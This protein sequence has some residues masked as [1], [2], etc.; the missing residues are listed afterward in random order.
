MKPAYREAETLIRCGAFDSFGYTRPQHL[1]RLRLFYDNTKHSDEGMFPGVVKVRSDPV[2]MVDYPLEK[3]LR[4]ELELMEL[5]VE[6]HPLWI[7]RGALR[8][9]VAKV[10]PFVY[11]REIHK[12]IGQNVTLVGWMVT[13]RRTKTKPGEMMQ[14]LSCED[15][16]GTYEAVLFPKAYRKYSCLIRSRGPYI[17]TG[18]VEDDFGHTLVTVEKLSMITNDGITFQHGGMKR[19]L[20]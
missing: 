20:R 13:T 5:T 4:D 17:I 8:E 15:L 9:H 10:G 14:L 7:W 18:K 2:P 19:S 12:Q 6:K 11:A 3:K 1:W 16:T